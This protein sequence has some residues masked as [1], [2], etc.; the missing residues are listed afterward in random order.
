M[1]SIAL[2]EALQNPDFYPHPVNS[3]VEIQQTHASIVLLAGDFAYKLKKPV[4]YGFLD[5][6]T[7]EKRKECIDRELFLNQLIA[8]EIYLEVLPIIESGGKISWNGEGEIVEYVLKMNR[9]PQECLL[10]Q[11]FDRGKLTEVEIE[12]LGKKIALFHRDARTDEYIAEFGRLETI[13]HAFDENYQQT[14][15]YIGSVQTERQFEETKAFT[16]DRLT[17]TND[18]HF[19]RPCTESGGQSPDKS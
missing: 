3:P 8:P 11:R 6:S 14:E 17:R 16:D 19:F 2:L 7:L 10:S 13:R 5:F 12:A 18:T 15:K 9:F 4:N 1:D